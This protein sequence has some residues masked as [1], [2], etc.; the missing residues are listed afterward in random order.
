M[1]DWRSRTP[2]RA[3]TA[4]P[5]TTG[6]AGN[7]DRGSGYVARELSAAHGARGG[8]T[9]RLG[10]VVD[11]EVGAVTPVIGPLGLEVD[12]R[13]VLAA[14]VVVVRGGRRVEDDDETA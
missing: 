4:S 9:G 14:R 2:A 6:T 8:V 3:S 10:R 11:P 13:H 7:D 1:C 5:S 12:L